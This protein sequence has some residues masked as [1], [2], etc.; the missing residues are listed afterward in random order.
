[1]CFV[2]LNIPRFLNVPA[3]HLFLEIYQKLNKSYVQGINNVNVI[4]EFN[5]LYASKEQSMLFI[6]KC[7]VYLEILH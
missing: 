7:F 5:S 3:Y 2:V 6:S 4:T 1:M